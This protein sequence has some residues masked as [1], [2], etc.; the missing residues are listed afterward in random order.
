MS[1]RVGPQGEP[2]AERVDGVHTMLPA[3]GAYDLRSCILLLYGVEYR[4]EHVFLLHPSGLTALPEACALLGHP[5]PPPPPPK[6]CR[7]PG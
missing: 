7:D 4:E 1:S 2:F 3:S 5:P 6:L